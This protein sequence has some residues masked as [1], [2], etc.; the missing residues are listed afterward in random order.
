MGFPILKYLVVSQVYYS[1]DFYVLYISRLF[2]DRCNTQCSDICVYFIYITEDS[3]SMAIW[4]SI[5]LIF[6]GIAAGVSTY[7]AIRKWKKNKHVIE[8]TVELS[9][10]KPSSRDV[11]ISAI[12]S[13]NV[14]LPSEEEFGKLVTFTENIGQRY[15]TSQGERYNKSFGFNLN[16][17]VLP[18]DHNRVKLRNPIDH[19]DYVNATWISRIVEDEPTYDQ[20]IYSSYVPYDNIN[21]IIGQD[22]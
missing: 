5:S 10:I 20:L 18:F 14:C 3:H 4:V 17:N 11:P 1:E 21:F 12:A 9:E 8:K 2:Y 13:G 6:L 15:T 22:P 16:R 7:V 19:C